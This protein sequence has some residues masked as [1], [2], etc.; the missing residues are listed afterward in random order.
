[1][2]FSLTALRFPYVFVWF[3]IGFKV[4]VPAGSSCAQRLPCTPVRAISACGERR[5]EATTVWE[6]RPVFFFRLWPAA[7]QVRSCVSCNCASVRTFIV[8][9]CS[10]SAHALDI[11]SSVSRSSCHPCRELPFGLRATV[12]CVPGDT[13]FAYSGPIAHSSVELSRSSIVVRRRSV[14]NFT[15]SRS[16]ALFIGGGHRR[17]YFVPC[18]VGFGYGPVPNTWRCLAGF[19]A[20]F[21]GAFTWTSQLAPIYS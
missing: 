18:L 9:V 7:S 4:C 16:E 20:A 19:L 1:M 5:E 3:S 17:L 15:H 10:M 13:R 14:P 6:G 21:S 8:S 11:V 2:S 12:T